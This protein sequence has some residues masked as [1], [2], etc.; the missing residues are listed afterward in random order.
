L[1]A[2]FLSELNNCWLYCPD[3]VI[4]KAYAFLAK[5]HTDARYPDEVKEN[6]F[7]ELMVAIR[8]DLLCRKPVSSTQLSAKDFNHL[9]VT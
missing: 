5:V 7:G 1:K 3:E 9:R 8:K 2:K 4:K 6:A